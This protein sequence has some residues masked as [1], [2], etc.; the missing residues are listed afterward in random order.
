MRDPA[1]TARAYRPDVDGLRALAVLA[2]VAYHVRVPGFGGGFVGVDAFFVISGFLITR[3]LLAEVGAEGRIGLLAFWARRIRRL[4]PALALMLLVALGVGAA[5]R[6]TVDWAAMCDQARAAALY[7]SNLFFAREASDYF[8]TGVQ[9]SLFLHTWSL[10]VEEQFYLVWPLLAAGAVALARRV[11]PAPRVVLGVAFGVVFVASLAVSE[12]LVGAGSSQAFYGLPS[13]AWEFAAAGLLAVL[14]TPLPPVRVAALLDR[15]PVRVALGA[16]GL[17]GLVAVVVLVH[18]GGPFPGLHALPV[19]VATM[20]VILAGSGT[21]TGPVGRL[22]GL[23]PLR[24]VGVT[25]YSWY[26]WHWPAILLAV[27]ASGRDEVW[28]RGLAALVAL[29]IGAVAYRL[30]ERPLRTVPWLVAPAWRTYAAGAVVTLA[31]VGAT[32]GIAAYARHDLAHGSGA[33]LEDLRA[34]RRREVCDELLTT[35]GGVPYCTG[36][37]PHGTKTVLIVGDSH[38]RHW[39]PGLDA[40]GDAM[41]V[42]LLIRWHSRCPAPAIEINAPNGSGPDPGCDEFRRGTASLIR[43]LRP[44]AV[45]VTDSTGYGPIVLGDHPNLTQDERNGVWRRAHAAYLRELR[46][47]GIAVG[48][49][50][51]TPRLPE[52]PVTCIGTRGV[53]ACAFGRAAAFSPGDPY[54]AAEAAARA[55]VGDVPALDIN[56][57]LCGPTMCP[58]RV[59][60]EYAYVDVDHLHDRFVRTQSPAVQAFLADVLDR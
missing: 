42:R 36:G 45:I 35:A 4:V 20:A 8:G 19:V 14:V 51:D 54:R 49:I 55:D 46:G 33:D 48:A 30:V 10:G 15:D 17:A 59:G 25:S 7:V 60:G 18:D 12:H 57:T 40:A 56:D 3:N 13:R 1:A 52:D 11:R 28:V 32:Y 34:S 47:Q 2:I 58:Q 50:V 9:R 27:D 39:A 44:D 29:G 6:P 31:V 43:E 37:D 24:V 41:G 53:D 5:V 22:L 23:R 21:E 26:L 16:A 38:A